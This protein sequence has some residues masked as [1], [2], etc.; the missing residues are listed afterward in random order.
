MSINKI[1][2]FSKEIVHSELFKNSSV[3]TISS[4]INAAI[5]FLLLPLLTTRLTP[6]DYGII[7][8][9]ATVQA[10]LYPILGVNLEGA[11]AR[12]FYSKDTD[13]AV[14][15]GNCLMIF[16]ITTILSFLLFYLLSEMIESYTYI[17]QNWVLLIPLVCAAQF[18]CMLALVLWQVR[19]MPLRYAGFQISQSGLNALLTLLF[20]VIFAYNWQ[21]R[22]MAI[23]LSAFFFMLVAI[24]YIIKQ[25][26]VKFKYNKTYLKHALIYGGGLIPHAI[27]SM[28]ILMTNRLF[29]TKMISVEESGMYAVSNQVCTAISFL[30]ISFNNAFV[31]WLFKK[32]TLDDIHEKVKI[33]KL[34]Y[35]YFVGIIFIGF[36]YFIIQPVLFHIFIGKHF[37]P[38]LSY[39]FWITLGFVFQGMYFMVTNYINYAEKT[40]LQAILTISIGL[41]NFPLNYFCITF[42]GAIGAAI[43]F[44][45]IYFIFFVSTWVLSSKVYKMPWALL[46]A[47]N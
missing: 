32:L 38:S 7:T 26:D 20:L 11:I 46:K 39:S 31:P 24:Y 43:S 30:T 14:Y 22:I 5:P 3:Y 21:G 25:R 17:P 18:V 29:L 45:A 28:L 33:V 15:I 37:L 19:E 40:H 9:F 41:L 27:G 23:F 2:F 13:L 10:F 47:S 42:F 36:L 1:L 4:I 16:A 35:L 12:K 34:T 6:A 44:A 8:M